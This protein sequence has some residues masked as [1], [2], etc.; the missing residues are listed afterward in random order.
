MFNGI[1]KDGNPTIPI[2]SYEEQCRV[3]MIQNRIWDILYITDT[4]IADTYLD[5]F[6][7]QVI[8]PVKTTLK[9]IKELKKDKKGRQIYPNYIN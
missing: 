7:Y 6:N 4:Q 8:F 9:C 5:L 3:H 1:P 2:N